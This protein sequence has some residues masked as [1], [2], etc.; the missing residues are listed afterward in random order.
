MPIISQFRKGIRYLRLSGHHFLTGMQGSPSD[1]KIAS[2]KDSL[3]KTNEELDKLQQQQTRLISLGNG[4]PYPPVGCLY[5]FLPFPLVL[6]VSLFFSFIQTT[7]V[8][9]SSL[10]KIPKCHLLLKIFLF[11]EQGIQATVEFKP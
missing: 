7:C 8:S 3:A 4:H 6:S 10:L 9:Q 1:S 2:L 5:L 11:H